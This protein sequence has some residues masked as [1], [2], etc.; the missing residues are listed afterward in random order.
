[1]TVE[2]RIHELEGMI[3]DIQ[4]QMEDPEKAADPAWMSENA[5]LMAAH[6]EEISSLYDEW[7]ELQE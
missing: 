5:S 2:E 6:E 3:A 1:M 7:M 4:D